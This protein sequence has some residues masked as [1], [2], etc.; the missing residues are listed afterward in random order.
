[1]ITFNSSSVTKPFKTQ[2]KQLKCRLDTRRETD[3]WI[4]GRTVG[5]LTDRQ[6]DRQIQRIT[7]NQTGRPI[8]W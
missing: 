2:P 8:D 4:D 7:D 5:W 3:R 6:K 1:L